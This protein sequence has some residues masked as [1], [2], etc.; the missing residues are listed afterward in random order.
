[1][2]EA[3]SYL[4]DHNVTAQRQGSTG[5]NYGKYVSDK[6]GATYEIWLQD[7]DSVQDE[8]SL[9]RDYDLAGVAAWK[10]GFESGTD[11]WDVTAQVL[12]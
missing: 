3:Q 10:I 12:K 1:M 5:L 7:K 4:T 8:V 2:T 9:I 11:I 6:D